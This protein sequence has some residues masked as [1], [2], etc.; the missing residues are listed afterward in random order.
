MEDQHL[1]QTKDK[2]DNNDTIRPIAENNPQ[3]DVQYIASYT[4]DPVPNG[5]A[6]HTKPSNNTSSISV[7]SNANVI[8]KLSLAATT[9]ASLPPSTAVTSAT[10]MSTETRLLPTNSS[11]T[12]TTAA[13]L[14]D[15]PSNFNVN[16]AAASA[17]AA[18]AAGNP[19]VSSSSTVSASLSTTATATIIHKRKAI[20]P[21]HA[22]GDNNDIQLNKNK[23]LPNIAT[24]KQKMDD[25]ES[26]SKT[27]RSITTTTSSSGDSMNISS[28]K[29]NVQEGRNNALAPNGN[30]TS[31]SVS[32]SRKQQSD[33]K[34][35]DDGNVPSEE[36]KNIITKATAASNEGPSNKSTIKNDN[37]VVATASS[38]VSFSSRDMGKSYDKN[39]RVSTMQTCQC[40]RCAGQCDN[41]VYRCKKCIRC[42][43]KKCKQQITT[44]PIQH[45]EPQPKPKSKAV[46]IVS[47]TK[48]SSSSDKSS[49]TTSSTANNN[50][51]RKR[52]SSP[53]PP[54]QVAAVVASTK[55]KE[56]NGSEVVS[57][58][59][60]FPTLKIMSDSGIRPLRS[61]ST[62][63][64]IQ[65]ERLF[66][67]D[68]GANDETWDE[69]FMGVLALTNS[70]EVEN[71]DGRDGERSKKRSLLE[72]VGINTE[73]NDSS[74]D[75]NNDGTSI[76]KIESN[77]SLELI[78]HVLRHV[79]N[80]KNVPKQAKL[81]LA[82]INMNSPESIAEAISRL[83]IDPIVLQQDGWTTT[84]ASEPMGAS[85][86]AYRI[87]EKIWWQGYVGVVIAFVHDNDMGDL[88]KGMWI[89]DLLTF[90]LEPE[91]LADSRK[92]Y[93][94]K[95]AAQS[96]SDQKRKL[97]QGNA[98]VKFDV[99]G[100]EHGII[101]ATSFARGA[102]HGVFWPARVMHVSELVG[103]HSKRG[104][105]KKKVDVVFLAPY[106]NSNHAMMKNGGGG[107]G[108]GGRRVEALSDSVLR[109]GEAIFSSGPL[110]EVE[111]TDADEASIQRYPY[112][113]ESGLD[114]D[115]L[116][117][118]FKLMGLP[119]DAFSRFLD[120]H[121]LALGFRTFSQFEMKSTRA[122]DSD[123]AAAALLEGHPLAVH[124]AHFPAS[125]L[126]LP[127]IHMLSQLPHHE[128]QT[129]RPKAYPGD[130][131][132]GEPALQFGRI[133][134]S[135]KPPACWGLNLD[136]TSEVK[137]SPQFYST[138]SSPVSF[139][140]KGKGSKDDP[141]DTGRFIVGLS[142]LH[143]LLSENSHTSNIL[144][145]SL[146]ELVIADAKCSS[147]QQI[148]GSEARNKYL[149]SMNRT[150]II[151]KVSVV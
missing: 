41:K 62:A 72:W 29:A 30:S 118:S 110:F 25:N 34:K 49:P 10:M 33:Q 84:K 40:N 32:D 59:T 11:H 42:E 99:D 122:S 95:K 133:L 47:T 135:M 3:N 146:N 46:P 19:T 24:K 36:K 98:K 65:L 145:N 147:L 14:S 149:R 78:S 97:T 73:I 48:K 54:P 126:Q 141:Y 20:E 35:E 86:G 74:T 92:K 28:T 93:E 5:T 103:V 50:N 4:S 123:R 43:K 53:K 107:G 44:E 127:F 113:A 60:T 106:W 15:K 88:W 129:F 26:A 139:S 125:A 71:P 77:N 12:T 104:R 16:A 91:E 112:D 63:E 7:M 101:L 128:K 102:R 2:E 70:N 58:Y 22:N 1:G 83:S 80:Y 21:P 8:P 55:K 76:V 144:K 108:G 68:N 137:E 51:N 151:V 39:T 114:I 57:L 134:D 45:P 9:T 111:I 87:G 31:V 136:G 56:N 90:D 75:N 61:L 115:S 52:S 81:I 119:K 121:R 37:K 116:R 69:H 85:G 132:K 150:W 117:L 96:S 109:H 89:E 79:Y 13:T 100:I 27:T 120:S 18:A 143:S 124:T 138:I 140:R 130:M 64:R 38:G 82:N 23:S 148:H 6:S 67:F 142:S 94:R 66:E 131:S 105:N 17:A